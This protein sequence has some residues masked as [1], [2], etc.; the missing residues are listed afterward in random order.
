M[1]CLD[2]LTQLNRVASIN[3]KSFRELVSNP[4]GLSLL[5]AINDDAYP[6][7]LAALIEE[8]SKKTVGLPGLRLDESNLAERKAQE[9]SLADS[10]E[11]KLHKPMAYPLMSI[12]EVGFVFS[13]SVKTIYRW[14]DEGKVTGPSK[15][16][17]RIFTDSVLALLQKGATSGE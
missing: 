4:I 10:V 17:G 7:Y 3:N 13:R 12:E 1:Q 11:I 16:G 15:V 9:L 14:R 5:T 8:V 6:E 2:S